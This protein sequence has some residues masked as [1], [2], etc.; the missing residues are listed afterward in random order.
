MS[1]GKTT[2]LISIILMLILLGCG[3]PGK[4]LPAIRKEA[5]ESSAVEEVRKELAEIR[6]TASDRNFRCLEAESIAAYVEKLLD[7][8]PVDDPSVAIA[9]NEVRVLFAV[10][11]SERALRSGEWTRKGA[12][13]ACDGYLTRYAD[14]DFCSPEVP[15]DWV[16]FTFDGEEYYVQPLKNSNDR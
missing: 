3:D 2:F 10:C 1:L 16:P 13:R 15:R 5:A 9:L 6:A 4:E 11:E 14:E 7:T 12:V 8:R